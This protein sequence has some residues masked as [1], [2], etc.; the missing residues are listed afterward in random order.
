LIHKIIQRQFARH[1]DAIN[2]SIQMANFVKSVTIIWLARLKEKFYTLNERTTA[3]IASDSTFP[4]PPVRV[5]A[6]FGIR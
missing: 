3:L 2:N 5:Y 6:V 4:S 1:T